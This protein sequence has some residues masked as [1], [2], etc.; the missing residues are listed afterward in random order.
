M[1][2]DGEMTDLAESRLEV[3]TEIKNKDKNK[4][5]NTIEGSS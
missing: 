2:D 1:T 3:K 5:M 4:D